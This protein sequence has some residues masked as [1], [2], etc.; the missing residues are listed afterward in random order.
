MPTHSLN[1]ISKKPSKIHMLHKSYATCPKCK[2][3]KW[4]VILGGFGL[5]FETILSFEC[6]SC[7]FEIVFEEVKDTVDHINSNNEPLCLEDDL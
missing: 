4:G 6:A 5:S 2:S 7:G 3:Q 1:D